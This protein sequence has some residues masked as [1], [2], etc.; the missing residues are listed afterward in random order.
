MQNKRYPL[1]IAGQKYS[2]EAQWQEAFAPHVEE[3][4]EAVGVLDARC[5]CL[6]DSHQAPSIMIKR[7]SERSGYVYIRTPGTGNLHAP[8]CV[9]HSPH[10]NLSGINCYS[11]SAIK[12]TLDGTICINLRKKLKKTPDGAYK[13][14]DDADQSKLRALGLKGILHL[15]WSEARLNLWFDHVKCQR[16]LGM[17]NLAIRQVAGR[18]ISQD[19]PL[20]MNL[21]LHAPI[22]SQQEQINNN[23]L[24]SSLATDSKTL[25]LAP[26]RPY[27]AQKH[28]SKVSKL[29]V[30]GNFGF[31]A[32][33]IGTQ[34]WEHFVKEHL[35]E[36]K[37]WKEGHTVIALA[38]LA[39]KNNGTF[40]IAQ[41]RDLTLMAV[42][43]AWIPITS[44][45]DQAK[46]SALRAEGV[47]FI[48]PLRYDAP[49]DLDIPDFLIADGDTYQPVKITS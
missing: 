27:N 48:K 39:T 10:Q 44:R 45:S 20:D 32:V 40:N 34:H 41:V 9:F 46:E 13:M 1:L 15:I 4:F 3:M 19:N 33:F 28:D 12:E 18:I 26:L 22:G 38:R 17:V 35:N 8:S 24:N 36:V 37:L 49:S 31:S 25:L 5:L 2:P 6:E 42:S 29:P 47:S 11:S 7:R 14:I 16:R 21:L 30:V 43:E 23:V